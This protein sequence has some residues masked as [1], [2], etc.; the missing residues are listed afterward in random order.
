MFVWD[1]QGNLGSGKT[2]GMSVFAHWF[3]A[4]A[5]RNGIESKLFANYSLVQSQRIM[6]YKDFYKVAES[7]AS[8][9]CVDEAHIN[10]DSR[11]FGRG[12]NVYLTQFLMYMRKLRASFFFASPT[13]FN[14]DRR[15][16]NLTNILVDCQKY[17]GGFHWEV[18]DYQSQRLIRKLFMPMWKANKIIRTGIYD[19]YEMVYS[20]DF[21]DSEDGFREFIIKLTEINSA[22]NDRLALERKEKKKRKIKAIV[23]PGV[24]PL[25]D[26][27]GGRPLSV[28]LPKSAQIFDSEAP[29]L[30]EEVLD[31]IRESRW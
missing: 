30:D 14:L 4:A 18:Y 8:I 29:E 20:I 9:V 28:L 5:A 10:L 26:R 12:K 19:T 16:R 2:F 17:R 23:N 6:G 21:P 22:S 24:L 3:K 25:E 27:E 13:I 7:S 1:F 11:L 15:M 31:G